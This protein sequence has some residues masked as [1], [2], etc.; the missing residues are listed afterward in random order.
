MWHDRDG[1][2]YRE[3]PSGAGWD[4]GPLR[5]EGLACRIQFRRLDG[6]WQQRHCWPT[7]TPI[8]GRMFDPEEWIPT[9]NPKDKKHK[10]ETRFPAVADLDAEA[11]R[12]G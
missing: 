3:G 6:R 12:W 5:F 11:E 4:T 1:N 2:A 7:S 9:H 8:L 10:I